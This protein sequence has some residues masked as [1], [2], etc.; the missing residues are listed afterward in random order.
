L[1]ARVIDVA[2]LPWQDFP[3]RTEIQQNIE[4][5]AQVA[6]IFVERHCITVPVAEDQSAIDRDAGHFQQSP[7]FPLKIAV[8]RL[9]E[10]WNGDQ[11]AARASCRTKSDG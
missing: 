11:P 1:P 3:V 9:L 6:K 10:G 8:I 7:I 4:I 2:L 5:P